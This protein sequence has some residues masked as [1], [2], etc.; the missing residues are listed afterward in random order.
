VRVDHPAVGA[1]FRALALSW[2]WR[3]YWHVPWGESTNV[4][5]RLTGGMRVTDLSR[6]PFYALGGVPSQ[7]VARAVIDSSRQSPTGFLRGYEQRALVG[8][9]FHLA[10]LEYRHQL[11]TVEHGL[12]TLPLFIKRVHAAALV[13]AGSAYETGS[14]DTDTVRWSVGGALR[15]DVFLGYFV[16][17]AFELGYSRGLSEGGIG[18]GWFFLT[19]T[20]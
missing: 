19:S 11:Y 10:N 15:V 6:G 2:Y 13:D 20:I 18:E 12:S 17:G 3:G 1:S 14:F 4:T 16:P 5:L 8:N 7:D 9:I